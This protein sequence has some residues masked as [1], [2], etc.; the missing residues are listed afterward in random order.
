M[1]FTGTINISANPVSS[2]ETYHRTLIPAEE[3]GETGFFGL[4]MENRA[5]GG[6]YRASFTMRGPQLFLADFMERGLGR[7]VE[8]MG[9]GGVKA[10]EGLITEMEYDAGSA[11]TRISLKEMY[12]RV[13]MRYRIRGSATTSRSTTMNDTDSQA[14]FGIK[15][16]VMSGGELESSDIADQATGAFLKMHKWPS[17]VPVSIGGSLANEHLLRVRCSG[18]FETLNWNVYNQTASTDNQGASA[19]ISNILADSDVAQFVASTS[20]DSNSTL[21]SRVYD[22]DRRGGDI[23][24]DIARLGDSNNNRWIAYMTNDRKFIFKEASPPEVTTT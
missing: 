1:E 11:A 13:W 6:Y 8:M 2:W 21:V 3:P 24:R 12:N 4:S 22:A 16:F 7:M 14:R 20:I 17:A 9:P 10:W 5:D 19:Q 18:F 23:I 15:T